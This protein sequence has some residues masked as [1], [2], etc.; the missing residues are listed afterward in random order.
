MDSLVYELFPTPVLKV[1]IL[2]KKQRFILDNVDHWNES[3]SVTNDFSNSVVHSFNKSNQSI[4]MLLDPE[5]EMLVQIFSTIS[6]G[7]LLQSWVNTC[8]GLP[9]HS[10]GNSVVSGTYYALYD[11]KKHEPIKYI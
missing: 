2:K 8:G 5:I 1:K 4:W 11:S 10:H 6:K 7:S 9:F 3:H